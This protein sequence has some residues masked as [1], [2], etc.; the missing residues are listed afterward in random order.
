MNTLIEHDL[1]DPL[2]TVYMRRRGIPR[3]RWWPV[4]LKLVFDPDIMDSGSEIGQ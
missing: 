1:Q 3:G 2:G 4:G